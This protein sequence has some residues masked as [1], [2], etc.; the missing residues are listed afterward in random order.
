MNYP[1][2]SVS[3]EYQMSEDE[4]VIDL[5]LTPLLFSLS[6]SPWKKA[7]ELP[8]PQVQIN[9]GQKLSLTLEK[10]AENVW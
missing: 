4:S 1:A 7:E 6:L 10:R 2:S 3:L 5:L 8:G 9:S